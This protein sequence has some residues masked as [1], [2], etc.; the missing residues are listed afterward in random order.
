MKIA[1]KVALTLLLCLVWPFAV[2]LDLLFAWGGGVGELSE[3]VT[4]GLRRIWKPP[5]PN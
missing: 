3:D 4:K 5:S 1:W 2:L